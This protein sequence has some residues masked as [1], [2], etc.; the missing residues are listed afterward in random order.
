[1]KLLTETEKMNL[2]SEFDV[3]VDILSKENSYLKEERKKMI[4]DI[5]EMS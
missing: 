3:K 1:M 4:K 2:K 5:K